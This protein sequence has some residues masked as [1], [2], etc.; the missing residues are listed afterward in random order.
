[1]KK[2]VLLSSSARPANWSGE[3]LTALL[4][5]LMDYREA[6][7]HFTKRSP[8]RR[9]VNGLNNTWLHRSS[10][11]ENTAIHLRFFRTNIITFYPDGSFSV[12]HDGY[13]APVTKGRFRDYLPGRCNIWAFRQ[14]DGANLTVLYTPR[15]L[16]PWK[17]G[18]TFTKDYKRTDLTKM[19]RED[20]GDVR[21]AI[22]EYARKYIHRAVYHGLPQPRRN[23]CIQC[24]RCLSAGFRHGDSDAHYLEHI[25]SGRM[26]SK[27]LLNAVSPP[28]SSQ[29]DLALCLFEPRRCLWMTPRTKLAALEQAEAELM[30]WRAPKE[31]PR[32]HLVELRSIVDRFLLERVGFEAVKPRDGLF[33]GMNENVP[34]NKLMGW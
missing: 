19:N 6:V 17:N 30:G 28:K 10:T 7:N 20:A 23:D 22:K 29:A 31:D 21:R 11:A 24:D 25:K 2:S 4:K 27:L 26:P 8:L 15:G 34:V 12:D 1:M 13:F 3:R 14:P 18:A 33:R 16:R 9:R 5:A 32:E